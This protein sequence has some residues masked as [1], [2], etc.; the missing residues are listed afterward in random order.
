MMYE[1]FN[2]NIDVN[3]I[4]LVRNLLKLNRYKI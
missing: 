1:Y 4:I 2:L 3:L